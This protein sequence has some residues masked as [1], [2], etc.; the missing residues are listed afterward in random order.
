M[1]RR[2]AGAER[3][4]LEIVYRSVAAFTFVGLYPIDSLLAGLWWLGIGLLLRFERKALGIATA[5]LGIAI[6]GAGL[7]WLLRVESFARLELFYFLEPFWAIWLG[8]VMWRSA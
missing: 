5:L 2:A 1:L 3:D 6:I 4:T 8:V 7:G